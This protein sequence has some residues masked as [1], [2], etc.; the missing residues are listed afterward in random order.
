MHREI[1]TTTLPDTAGVLAG[2]L[3]PSGVVEPQ[4]TVCGVSGSSNGRSGGRR[5]LGRDGESFISSHS[6]SVVISSVTRGYTCGLWTL[7][8]FI[9]VSA[10]QRA[11]TMST[12]ETATTQPAS[13]LTASGPKKGPLVPAITISQVLRTINVLVDQLFGCSMCRLVICLQCSCTI[14]EMKRF[15]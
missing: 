5:L 15:Y 14:T 2:K 11:K 10:A 7:L 8:H 9:T 3:H 13:E 4:W 12:S 6:P 1:R